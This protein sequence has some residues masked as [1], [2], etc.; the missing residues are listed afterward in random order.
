M[1]FMHVVCG[2]N[3]NRVISKYVNNYDESNLH[4]QKNRN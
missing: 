3:F 4:L 2:K 1:Q